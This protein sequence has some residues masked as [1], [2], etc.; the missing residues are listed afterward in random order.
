M[1]AL[2][3]IAVLGAIA[4][5]SG[6]FVGG[7]HGWLIVTIPSALITLWLVG[8]FLTSV[9]SHM[10]DL[11]KLA[12]LKTSIAS[13]NER[14]TAVKA[15]AA[16]KHGLP[17]QLLALKQDDNPV[18]KYMALVSNAIV[19]VETATDGYNRCLSQIEARAVGPFSI[20]VDVLG[21]TVPE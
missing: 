10:E 3:T 6:S 15:L 8:C 19:N 7:S 2:I 16:D 20:V 11:A 4:M 13:A 21:S 9:T 17:E 1:K 18:T 14:L 12:Y 5:L